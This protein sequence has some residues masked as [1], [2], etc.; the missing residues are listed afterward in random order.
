MLKGYL[1]VALGAEAF[2]A[3][4]KRPS[5]MDVHSH[6]VL[7]VPR[8]AFLQP[9]AV[10]EDLTDHREEVRMRIEQRHAEA[11]ATAPA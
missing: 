1:Q 5:Q 10:V 4:S 7:A 3:W 8:N 9:L 6:G 11:D 2:N